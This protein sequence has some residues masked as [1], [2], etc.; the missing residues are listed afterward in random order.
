MNAPIGSAGESSPIIPPPPSMP[1]L[2]LVPSESLAAAATPAVPVGLLFAVL[3]LSP[4]PSFSPRLLRAVAA[5]GASTVGELVGRLLVGDLVRLLV[6]LH[7][8]SLLLLRAVLGVGEAARVAAGSRASASVAALLGDA[9]VVANVWPQRGLATLRD[10]CEVAGV[11]CLDHV[12]TDAVRWH[13]LLGARLLDRVDSDAVTIV[14]AWEAVWWCADPDPTPE[15]IERARL[16]S[17]EAA[18]AALLAVVPP[19]AWEALVRYEAAALR[20]SHLMGGA[21]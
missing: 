4:S 20:A 6:G 19:D 17:Q 7:A 18:R 15:G 1:S 14:E 21:S 5:S 8:G 9:N 2:A 10:A 12:H 16:A 11:E 13:L 3:V